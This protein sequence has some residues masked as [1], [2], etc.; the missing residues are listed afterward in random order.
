MPNVCVSMKVLR[1]M[2]KVKVKPVNL[3]SALYQILVSDAYV[4]HMLMRDTQVLPVT[5]PH[6]QSTEGMSHTCIYVLST[7]SPHFAW[8]SFPIPLRAGGWVGLGDWLRTE[9]VCLRCGHPSWSKPGSA[10]GDV[11][12]LS[13]EC[14]WVWAGSQGWRDVV[15]TALWRRRSRRSTQFI[16]LQLCPQIL[17]QASASGECTSLVLSCSCSFLLFMSWL[18]PGH[19]VLSGVVNGLLCARRLNSWRCEYIY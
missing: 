13:V 6:V 5:H 12:Q 2:C 11:V 10:W 15:P 1:R 18:R 3:Y 14:V 16:C 7:A 4:G 17:P 19:V 8:Y 9:T